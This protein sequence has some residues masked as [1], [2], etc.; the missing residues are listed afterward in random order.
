MFFLS[1]IYGEEQLEENLRFIADALSN[2][3]E[4]AVERIHN[5]MSNEFYFYHVKKYQDMK[6]YAVVEEVNQ[7]IIVLMS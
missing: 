2:S 5:Y 6:M 1:K 4:S 3:E 7:K